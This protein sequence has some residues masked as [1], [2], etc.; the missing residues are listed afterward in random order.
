MP[1]RSPKVTPPR[2][3]VVALLQTC[4]ENPD[5]DTPR[6]ILADWLDDHGD[7]ARAEFIRVQC[8]AAHLPLAPERLDWLARREGELLV[9]AGTE[10]T[11]PL[12]DW[13]AEWE[14]RRGMCLW[15]RPKPEVTRNTDTVARLFPRA[16]QLAW[17]EG[18]R[19]YVHDDRLIEAIVALPQMNQFTR[20]HIEWS[21]WISGVDASKIASV[22]AAAPT[23]A[24]V[25]ELELD[26]GDLSESSALA[27]CESP[28]LRNLRELRLSAM[29]AGNARNA[30]T[31]RFGDGVRFR[32]DEFA[33]DLG[34]S[35]D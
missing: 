35:F 24:G 5:D 32:S 13:A 17:V 22:L 11:Q 31:R 14:W 29:P 2:P 18:L 4:K 27:I 19:W 20:L 1:K 3:E 21:G 16:E 6:L 10:W 28:H 26:G 34:Y 8:E 15:A 25:R 23:L 12:I 33:V 9:A 7:T 30:L